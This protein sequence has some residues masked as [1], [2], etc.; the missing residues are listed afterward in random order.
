MYKYNA[1]NIVTLLTYCINVGGGFT[2]K[3]ATFGSVAK[4][5]TM[6]TVVFAAETPDL[7]YTGGASGQVYVW[8]GL[9]LQR[10]VKAHEGPCFTLH[11]L[12]KV[13]N[14]TQSLLYG[15]H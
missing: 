9:E 10:V 5:D 8:A 4:I 6:M 15:N 14:T 1:V 11:S 13:G 2:S 3:R 12:D 7:V